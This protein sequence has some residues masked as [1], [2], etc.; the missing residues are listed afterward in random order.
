M[1][2]SKLA[3]NFKV[4]RALGEMEKDSRWLNHCIQRFSHRDGCF[5]KDFFVVRTDGKNT[6]G[7]HFFV[8]F[9]IVIILACIFVEA[10]L[11]SNTSLSMLS[12]RDAFSTWRAVEAPTVA[13]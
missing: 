9:A 4:A 6:D 13:S 11:R 5:C 7:K 3:E 10:R 12:A 8:V 1:P 2:S